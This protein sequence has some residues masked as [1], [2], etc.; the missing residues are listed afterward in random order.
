M[1]DAASV[2]VIDDNEDDRLLYRRVLQKSTEGRYNVSE[3]DDGETGLKLI[4]SAPPDCVLL[5]Y[6]L[7]GR[8]GI[9]VLK[10][11]RSQHPFIP[12][13]MLTGQGNEAVAV[14]AIHE[15]AQNYI[16]KSTIT[17]DNLPRVIEM[18]IEHCMLEKR[19]HEQRTSL[20]VFTRALA[21]DLK[22]PVRT[23]R[24]FVEMIAEYEKFSEKTARYFEHIQNAADRMHML[25]DTVYYYTRLNDPAQMVRERCDTATVLQEVKENADHL[26]RQRQATVTHD[27]LPEVYV[28]R[29]QLTQLLQN[30]V[31]NAI[32]HS[33]KPVTIRVSA[34]EQK[35][36]YLFRVADNGPGIDSAYLQKIFEP[37]KR[38]SHNETQGAGLGL[39]ICKKI[40]EFY[41]GKIWCE[42]TPGSGTTFV[43]TLPKTSP[44][45]ASEDAWA[46]ASPAKPVH[47]NGTPLANVLLVDD[48]KADIEMTQFR[49]FERGHL[50]CNL[51]VASNGEEAL[52]ML[53]AR[54][55]EN[56]PIDLV[57]LDINMPEMDG[58]ELLEKMRADKALQDVVVVMCTGSIYDKD[59][60]RA[61]ALG[62]AGYLT[63]PVEFDKLKSLIDVT[64]NFQLHRQGEIYALLRA[65]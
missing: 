31:C 60:A 19:I 13:V 58:F 65:A 59:M 33:E 18:A 36:M 61:R 23:V 49:L 14:A 1:A 62:A 6:S 9:E 64:P 47:L 12:V 7:P 52:A 32:H 54:A 21:H 24:S 51:A 30:L 25:I 10:R 42:S 28:N 48:S 53:R 26:I 8:N 50:H 4:E 37:F 63:K 15:G 3:A 40:V 39:A 22:E 56:G 55:K 17:A 35:D 45:T 34:E 43:F 41:N 20:E 57:L 11:L 27:A 2:L 5:D 38:L 44:E 46:Q 16:A 29:T